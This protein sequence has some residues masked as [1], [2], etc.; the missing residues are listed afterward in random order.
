MQR[1]VVATARAAVSGGHDPWIGGARKIIDDD[2]A[3]AKEARA[4]GQRVV[5]IDPDAHHDAAGRIHRT[6]R[7]AH[8]AHLAPFPEQFGDAR[9]EHQLRTVGAMHPRC[10]LRDDRGH[11]S[12]HQPAQA[13]E[14]RNLEAELA[15]RGRQLQSDKST[16]DHHERQALCQAAIERSENVLRVIDRAQSVY[17]ARA[18]CPAP[19]GCAP[20]LRW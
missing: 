1:A 14:H 13:L 6:V 16:A 11:H 3:F 19:K 10:R 2:P 12:R 5:R 20:E 17:A 18:R 7:H 15:R 8:R 9:V 4:L